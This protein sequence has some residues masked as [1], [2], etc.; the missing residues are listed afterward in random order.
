MSRVADV[1][2]S[3]FCFTSHARPRVS[4]DKESAAALLGSDGGDC[5]VRLREELASERTEVLEDGTHV[6][7][8]WYLSSSLIESLMDL[9]SVGKSEFR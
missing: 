3:L 8:G 1:W 9:T 6:V 2:N 4:T 7:A 5:L